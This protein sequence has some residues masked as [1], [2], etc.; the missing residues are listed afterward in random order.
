VAFWMFLSPVSE[1]VPFD[2]REDILL[3][4]RLLALERIS[5][6]ALE[7]RQQIEAACL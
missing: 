2:I 1:S 6:P 5:P 3:Q 4:G 7:Y